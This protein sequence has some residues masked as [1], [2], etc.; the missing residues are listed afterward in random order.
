MGQFLGTK[1]G[2]KIY[3]RKGAQRELQDTAANRAERRNGTD[4]GRG[5]EEPF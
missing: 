2:T 3:V 5:I 1:A 4:H